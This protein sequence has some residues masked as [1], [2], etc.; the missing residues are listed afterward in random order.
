MSYLLP[1]YLH[2][3]RKQRGLSQADLAAL[4]GISV[5][6]LS[7]IEKLS[8]RPTAELMIEAELIFGKS[9]RDIFPGFYDEVERTMSD[10]AHA[11]QDLLKSKNEPG[12]HAEFQLLAKIIERIEKSKPKA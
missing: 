8:R 9:A 4:L 6:A 7:R 1:S 11:Q 2:T 3:L 12:A 5:S 10:R